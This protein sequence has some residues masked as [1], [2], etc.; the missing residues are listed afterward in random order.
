MK[1]LSGGKE[2]R[3]GA[4]A[5]AFG[6]ASEN[7]RRLQNVLKIHGRS[8]NGRRDATLVGDNTFIR[9]GR[10]T[11]P[12]S[13]IHL[14]VLPWPSAR[15]LTNTSVALTKRR[16][17]RLPPPRRRRLLLLLRLDP[18]NQIIPDIRLGIPYFYRI[19][20]KKK[21]KKRKKNW[22]NNKNSNFIRWI[23]DTERNSID[24]ISQWTIGKVNHRMQRLNRIH[25]FE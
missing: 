22:K 4:D 2:F 24:N 13:A 21:K 12:H 3:S 20:C 17:R 18:P 14:H 25:S 19:L 6:C 1:E 16:P 8:N 7:G 15:L 10:V 5:S 23:V 11:H 9:T